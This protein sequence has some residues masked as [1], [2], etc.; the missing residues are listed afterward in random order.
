MKQES[1]RQITHLESELNS[2]LD[3]FIKLETEKEILLQDR[4]V[5]RSRLDTVIARL[6]DAKSETA[7]VEEAFKQEINAQTSLAEIYKSKHFLRSNRQDLNNR[8][9]SFI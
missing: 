5:L 3:S 1:S 8:H 7:Q 2:K 4:D 6:N 9:V